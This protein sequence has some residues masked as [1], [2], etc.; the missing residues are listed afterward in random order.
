ME[1]RDRHPRRGPTQRGDATLEVPEVGTFSEQVWGA[2]DERH[3]CAGPLL[4]AR[5]IAALGPVRVLE[6]MRG[7]E[8]VT[9]GS[10]G[11]LPFGDNVE[12]LALYG[13]R[14][15]RGAG[16]VDAPR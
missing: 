7:L 12:E 4:D 5:R 14:L 16:R 11:Y 3:Q 2:S 10:D 13:R 8:G 1:V 15:H 6:W 9:A